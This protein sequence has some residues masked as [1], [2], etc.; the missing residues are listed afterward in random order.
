MKDNPAKAV[1]NPK[2][3]KN[4]P[5]YLSKEEVEELVKAAETSMEKAIVQL[6][7]ETGIRVSELCSLNIQDV[8]LKSLRLR[9]KGKGKRERILFFGEAAKEALI[10]YLKSERIEK[11][12]GLSKDHEALFITNRGRI[13]DTTVRRILK[14]LSIKAG[15]PKN[16][17][18]HLLRHT[19]ATHLLEE[20]VNLRGVQELLG[21]KNIETTEVY[22]HVSIRRLME[23]YDRAHPR[24][25]NR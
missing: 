20:G 6:M 12:K 25:K 21:H 9:V 13:S 24:A 1:S 18:P 8:D 15:L 4:L 19:F 23:I 5:G 7:Y 17:Y 11:A 3:G 22:T 16:V 10:S 2:V 14:K